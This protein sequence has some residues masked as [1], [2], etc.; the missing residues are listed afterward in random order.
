MTEMNEK[1]K[2]EGSVL[3]A[4]GKYVTWKG[5]IS[6]K[7]FLLYHLYAFVFAITLLDIGVYINKHIAIIVSSA[8][9]AGLSFLFWIRRGHDLGWSGTFAV[10]LA[11]ANVVTFFP[12]ASEA[13]LVNGIRFMTFGFLIILL[14][15]KGISGSNRFGEDPVAW[16]ER[17]RRERER[18]F[19]RL[20]RER[21]RARVRALR[22]EQ[23]QERWKKI[24]EGDPIRTKPVENKPVDERVV[25]EYTEELKEE[26]RKTRRI[27]EHK[28]ET[29]RD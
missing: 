14:S 24:I 13:V 26:G 29:R 16:A 9:F 2:R 5:R 3:T 22:E 8:V 11:A 21:L 15:K 7:Q 19:N 6:R 27:K 17:R 28:E 25:R 1:E 18:H 4:L 12:M 10:A 20:K 23:R